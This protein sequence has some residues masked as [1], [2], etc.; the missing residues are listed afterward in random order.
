L[1]DQQASNSYAIVKATGLLEHLFLCQRISDQNKQNKDKIS[2]GVLRHLQ[3]I[4]K[5][6]ARRHAS[7]STRHQVWQL[8]KTQINLK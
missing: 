2:E 1:F 7:I 4:L 8:E 3:I 5:K 6:T